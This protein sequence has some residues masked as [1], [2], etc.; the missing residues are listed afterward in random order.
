MPTYVSRVVAE[1]DAFDA[2]LARLTA[3]LGA[4]APGP[5]ASEREQLAAQVRRAA[6]AAARLRVSIGITERTGADIVDMQVRIQGETALL[7]GALRAVGEVAARLQ[8]REMRDRTTLLPDE[9]RD[10][11]GRLDER[12]QLVASALFPGAVDGLRAVNL[13]LWDFDKVLWKRYSDLL[14]RLVQRGELTPDQQA[15]IQEVAHGIRDGF[16]R[17]NDLLNRLA[18]DAFTDGDSLRQDVRDARDVLRAHLRAARARLT[19]SVERFQPMVQ[20]A[21]AIADEV[22]DRLARLRVPIFP[23]YARLSIA[24]AIDRATYESLSGVQRFALLNITARMQETMVAGQ[25]LWSP[26]YAMAVTAVFPDRIYLDADARLIQRVRGDRDQFDEAPASLHRFR[27]GSYKQTTFAKGNL[28]LCYQTE[29]ARVH[30]DADIDLFASPIRHLF[31]EVLVNHL[32]GN[33]TDQF[34]VRRILDAQQVPPIAGFAIVS[35][36]IDAA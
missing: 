9:V 30:L 12:A 21:A 29:G 32:T 36:R 17:V 23:P 28:Q 20:K 7:A 35:P 25:P 6:D 14:T 33:T 31:G 19:K 8:A 24:D 34:A 22:D 2:A 16:A 13:K 18:T 4:P 27:E 1:L 15:R 3:A 26:D 10:A 5:P 11:A